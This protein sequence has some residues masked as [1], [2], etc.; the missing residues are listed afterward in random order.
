[1]K[2]FVINQ[3]DSEQR[4]DKFLVKTL[5][6]LPKSLLYKSLRKKRIKVNGKRSGGEQK[7]SE[8][9][10]VEIYLNDDVFESAGDDRAFMTPLPAPDVVF[11]DEN[12]L[13]VNKPA[14]LIVHED[15]NERT[16]TLINRILH[17]LFEKG[18]YIP[19][20]EN[21]FAPALCNRIDRGTSGIVIAAKNAASLRV[22]TNLIRERRIQK[23]YVCVTVG[24][25]SPPAAVRSAHLRKD[26]KNNLVTI[27]PKAVPGSKEITTGYRTLGT[28]NGLALLEVELITGRTHQIR[29]HMAY[30][31]CG[32]LGDTKYGDFAANRKYGLERQLLCSHRLKFDTRGMGEHLE[33]LDGREFR[34]EQLPFE[35]MF[36]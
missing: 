32:L 28:K 3:N 30:L 11:E 36:L 14:G 33:Y 8:G 13:L 4:L 18:E 19:E 20:R 22:M 35:D 25:P 16:D 6:A 1:M 31:G 26:S 7:L 2:S 27:F 21:S 17:Y 29:A 12:I 23:H 9:D 34:L 5:P 15:E 10:V 24:A